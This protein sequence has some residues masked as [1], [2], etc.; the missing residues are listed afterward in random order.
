MVAVT[1][2]V[3]CAMAATTAVQFITDLG[4]NVERPATDVALAADD[5]VTDQICTDADSNGHATVC[6]GLIRG[7]GDEDRGHCK[8]GGNR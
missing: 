2:V 5:G 7:A 4:E 3:I 8:H 1:A 6:L